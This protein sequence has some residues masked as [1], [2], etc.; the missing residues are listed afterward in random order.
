MAVAPSHAPSKLKTLRLYYQNVRGLRTKLSDF[1]AAITAID[2]DLFFITETWLAPGITDEEVA[3][4]GYS[5]LRRDRP[6]TGMG[7][8]AAIVVA[9]GR[10]QIRE[11]QPPSGISK[12][13]YE[14][15][16]A[17]IYSCNKLEIVAIC[18]Y[19]PPRSKENVYERM[20]E[21]IEALSAKYDNVI[22][23]GD[24]NLNS[25]TQDV[26]YRYECLL[27]QCKLKQVNDV[28]NKKDEILDVVLVRASCDQI[29][30]Q[31][32]V[33]W[34][35]KPDGYHPPLAIELKLV[36]SRQVQDA[37]AS[38][39]VEWNFKKA[40][41]PELYECIFNLD[42]EPLYNIESPQEA[43]NFLYDILNECFNK[44]VPMKPKIAKQSLYVYPEWYSQRTI[45]HIRK[46]AFYHRLYKATNLPKNRQ[47][48]MEYRAKVKLN[49]HEDFYQYKSRMEKDFT[50]DPSTFWGYVASKRSKS[51]APK[52]LLH[53][54]EVV[55]DDQ[56]ASLF[57]KY[58]HSVYASQAPQLN[59]DQVDKLICSGSA[60]V[61]ISTILREDVELALKI[62]KPKRSQ[63]S[64]GIPPFVVKDCREV[65]CGPLH[66]V[67]RLCYD[68]FFYPDI[69]KLSRVVPVPK[70][71]GSEVSDYRPIAVLSVFGKLFE[72]IL[73]RRI[74]SQV[75]NRLNDAQHGFRPGRSTTSNLLSFWS[76]VV[77]SVDAGVQVDAAY[78]DFRKAFDTV[79]NDVLLE[80]LA[81]AGFTPHLLKFFSEYL[82]NR[83]QYVHYKGFVSEPYFT[84]SGV[85]QG[86]NLGPLEFLLF[87]DD[88]PETVSTAGCLLFA[89]DLKLF[90]GIK[91]HSDSSKFQADIDNVYQ[92]SIRNKLFFNNKKCSIVSFTR[93]K[94]PLVEH[95]HLGGTVLPRSNTIKD[96]GVHLSA[97]L[98]FRT[99]VQTICAQAFRML[100]FVM[101]QGKPLDS[102]PALKALYNAFVR[103]KLEGNALIWNPHDKV[104]IESVE[105]LQRKFLRWLYFKRYGYYVGYPFLYPSLFVNGM[106]GYDTLE[107][108]RAVS[109]ITFVWRII[110]GRRSLPSVLERMSFKVP[111]NYLSA[112]GH[113]LFHISGSRTEAGRLA[114]VPRA[115]IM[116]N[117]LLSMNPDLD[118]FN[119][120]EAQLCSIIKKKYYDIQLKPD[121]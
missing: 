44:W 108:R 118:L 59:A 114:P 96:L 84:F 65:L 72:S 99:H 83:R 70:S 67:F 63:G 49:M 21:S 121:R 62:L 64:D 115:L 71:S 66:H 46:K 34:Q 52:K 113:N 37:V 35:K 75:G 55:R 119:S 7:G 102:I 101:R 12:D 61:H 58:F 30:V 97:D 47:R 39:S 13:G 26:C 79:E 23:C 82:R 1:S 80:K 90:L 29:L 73:Q 17:G 109:L 4:R 9:P 98:S 85:S 15:T 110:S 91:D 40:N 56:A 24:F 74:S 88:L 32:E 76:Y 48:F 103:S 38:N 31:R 93:A 95:Y 117:K 42:W 28:K 94:K 54:G 60:R 5:V 50:R 86:S 45:G 18:T 69:W 6:G 27:S 78:F 92:W 36:V 112:R 11:I 100:G 8:G 81:K 105:K 14:L 19:L 20:F 89:D 2:A 77:E 68:H 111:N 104:Y 25:C 57:A 3:P 107:L 120:S 53:E 87:I 116:L 51:K 43:V 106:L 33:D 16:C 41:F 22:I 10:Y